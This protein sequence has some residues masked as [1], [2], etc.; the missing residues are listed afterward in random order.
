MS[1]RTGDA[2]RGQ[3][4]PAGAETTEDSGAEASAAGSWRETVVMI[5]MES[6]PGLPFPLF[7]RKT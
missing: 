5:A 1:A 3:E 4:A 6:L 7:A 2:R